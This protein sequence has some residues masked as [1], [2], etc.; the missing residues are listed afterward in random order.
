MRR[1]WKQKWTIGLLLVVL[2]SGF[3]SP[4]TAFAIS[5][6]GNFADVPDDYYEKANLLVAIEE[7]LRER[8]AVFF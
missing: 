6:S 3:F 5:E 4:I 2:L 7:E 8:F 1:E